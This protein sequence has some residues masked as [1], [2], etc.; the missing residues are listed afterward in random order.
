MS[1]QSQHL[2]AILNDKGAPL[3]VTS[4]PTPIPG[5]NDVLVQVS[6]VALNPIDYYM[7]D[8]GFVIDNYPAVIGSDIG[9][10]II[11]TGSSANKYK[12]GT[13]VAAFA[14][15]FFVHGAPDYGAFQAMA[16]IPE[17]NV[18][19]L[20]QNVSFNEASLLGMSV[21]TAWSGWWTI[22]FPLSD[23]AFSATDKKAVLV[24]GGAS[25]I[26]TGAVQSAKMIGLAVYATASEKHHDYIKQLG[27]KEVFDYKDADVVEKIVKAAKD[28]GVI[29]QYAFDAAGQVQP[30]L[31][32]LKNFK[33]G[34]TPQLATAIPM[35]DATP[36]EEGVEV[37][38]VA[39]PTEAKEQTEFFAFV[40]NSWLKEKLEKG[41]YKPSP[42]I[43]VV[44]GGL[45]GLN[46][47][48]DELKGGV[49]GTKLVLEL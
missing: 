34:G 4:R 23:T 32:I 28:D 21:V 40:M 2:A 38:F 49:S 47:G 29:V 12:P 15:T 22:G 24:W 46:K 19:P 37:K 31:D 30:C 5:P 44:E 27:A 33:A 6:S 9:G 41:K 43:K 18:T 35:S 3:S 14:P 11:S 8:F 16:L 7:R 48:L 1:S 45:G 17:A 39:A 25:S 13:R 42:A 36:K 10:T 20:P 26:G